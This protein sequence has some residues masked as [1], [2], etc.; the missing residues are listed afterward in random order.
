MKLDK[1][2]NNNKILLKKSLRAI[3]SEN[4]KVLLI[5]A[6]NEEKDLDLH[7]NKITVIDTLCCQVIISAKQTF[8]KKELNFKIIK[9]S[10]EFNNITM[11]L[12]LSKTL[13]GS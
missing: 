1:L 5:E 13:Q 12:G 7:A 3:D 9:P 11:L 6:L 10:E 4:L 8:L 2:K